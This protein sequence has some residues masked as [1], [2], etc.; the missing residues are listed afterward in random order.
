[1]DPVKRFLARRRSY[2]QRLLRLVA[3]RLVHI[4]LASVVIWLVALPLVMYRYHLVAPVAL[5]LNLF[6]WIPIALALFSGF[7][8]L[9]CGWWLPPVAEFSAA[10]CSASLGS[11]QHA[12]HSTAPLEYSHFWVVGPKAWWVVLFY[13]AWAVCFSIARLRRW[14][15]LW[16]TV[17]YGLLFAGCWGLADH[18]GLR[19]GHGQRLSCTFLSMGHGTCVVLELPGS[20]TWLYDA[21]CLGDSRFSGDTI[22]R[23]LW[24][25]GISRLRGIVLSHADVD[26]YNAVPARATAV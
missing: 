18:E 21:G 7:G 6:L 17:S 2:A 25:R 26:H 22:S 19:D 11:L 3:G 14:W 23:F 16:T 1:M 12:V 15:P 8:V 10:I 24:D 5:V 9:L 20:G 13:S 4:G